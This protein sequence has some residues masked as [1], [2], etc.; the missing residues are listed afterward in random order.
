MKTSAFFKLTA[1]IVMTTMISSGYAL[2]FDHLT[3]NDPV[4]SVFLSEN[5]DEVKDTTV[6]PLVYS[7]VS[8]V[9]KC[10]RE[11]ICYPANAVLKEIEGDVR[12]LCRVGCDGH[13]TEAKVLSSTNVSLE[14]EVLRA[15]SELTFMPVIENGFTKSYT[16]IIPV[17]FRID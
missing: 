6:V 2:A 10:L 16:L 3:V 9:Q 13:V 7:D 4:E 12:V 14:K 15:V 8:N 17:K 11:K 5:I 1:A